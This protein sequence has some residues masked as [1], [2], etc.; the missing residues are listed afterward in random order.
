[1]SK[2]IVG[3]GLEREREGRFGRGECDSASRSSFGDR[4]VEGSLNSIP[5]NNKLGHPK[6]GWSGL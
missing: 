3:L 6:L 5:P 4:I 2:A 1:M